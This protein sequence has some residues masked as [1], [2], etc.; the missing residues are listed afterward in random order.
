MKKYFI[1]AAA[2]LAMVA[3][4][5]DESE[6][7]AVAQSE[8]ISFT[9]GMANDGVTRAAVDIQG[10]AFATDELV[11]I[12]VTPSATGTMA[13][14]VYKAGA[15][16]G[17]VN[18]LTPNTG[19]TAFTWPATGT[20]KIEAFYPS[21][22]TSDA[23]TFS[24]ET[25]QSGDVNYKKSDLMYSTSIAAQAKQATAVGLTFNHALTK[26]IVKL[27]PGNG[28]TIANLKAATTTVE[29]SAKKTVTKEASALWS[30]AAASGDATTI[31]AGSTAATADDATV[32]TGAAAIIVPQTYAAN[33]D[34]I[35]VKTANDDQHKVTFKL[36]EAKTFEAGKC[37]TYKLTVG[38]AGISLE[39][40]TITNWDEQTAITPED[41]VII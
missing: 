25:D 28:I 22:V 11:N 14:K 29:L 38:L 12:E 8:V 9:A 41:P 5:N 40:T 15:A 6:N 20:V 37:Y 7:N 3:C 32:T 26:I 16:S 31:I 33:A 24:V 30:T 34:F 10:A 36:S 4:S 18:A 39:S 27:V 1:L 35:T 13:S 21:T 23:T 17:N 2:A 19:V